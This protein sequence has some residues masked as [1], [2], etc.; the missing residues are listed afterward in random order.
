MN[1]IHK[2]YYLLC[3]GAIVSVGCSANRPTVESESIPKPKDEKLVEFNQ[4]LGNIQ[5]EASAEDA[6]GFFVDHVKANL[7]NIHGDSNSNISM[8]KIVLQE[9]NLLKDFASIELRS[10]YKGSAKFR[11]EESDDLISCEKVAEVLSLTS[12]GNGGKLEITPDQVAFTQKVIRENIP[13]LAA[14]TTDKMTPLEASV[15]SYYI[16]TGDVSGGNEE[17]TLQATDEDLVEFVNKLQ[18]D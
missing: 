11:L 18:E 6:V 10:R 8:Q 14:N 2:F 12:N 9:K 17:G 1:K 3:L 4:K 5:D 7:I 16:L 15:L 13:N